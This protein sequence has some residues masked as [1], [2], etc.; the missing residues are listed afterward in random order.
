MTNKNGGWALSPCCMIELVPIT[1]TLIKCPKC[2]KRFEYI[3]RTDSL[4]GL[5]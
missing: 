1:K 2:N 3:L 4:R 5:K